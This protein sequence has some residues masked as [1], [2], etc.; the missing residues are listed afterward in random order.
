[1]GR[2]LL[3][4]AAPRLRVRVTALVAVACFWL[5]F[6]ASAGS[7]ASTACKTLAGVTPPTYQ[8][9]TGVDGTQ[10]GTLRWALTCANGT[11]GIQETIAFQAPTGGAELVV[12][13]T[14]I[15]PTITDRV[16]VVGS[17]DASGRPL[18]RI[19]GSSSPGAAYG[20]MSNIAAVGLVGSIQKIMF[21]GWASSGADA[22]KL[23]GAGRVSVTGSVFG[24]D[25]LS[26]GVSGNYTG[27]ELGNNSPIGG[28]TVALRN[29]FAGNVRGIQVNGNGCGAATGGCAIAGNLIGTN[30]SGTAR[31]GNTESGIRVENAFASIS[32][33][34]IAG[35]QGTGIKFVGGGSG[36]TVTGNWIGTSSAG[37]RLENL[38]PGISIEGATGVTVG[39]P[40][41]TDANTI[42]F[43]AR[44][45]TVISGSGNIFRG[46]KIFGNSPL[47]IDLANDGPTANDPG[48][49]DPGA[50]GR[51][52]Y[53][54]LSSAFSSGPTLTATM[55]LDSAPGTYVVDF[56]QGLDNDC[57]PGSRG[58][59]TSSTY[60]GSKTVTA[61]SSSQQ[62][63]ITIACASR[64]RNHRHDGDEPVVGHIGDVELPAVPRSDAERRECQRFDARGHAGDADPQC[65]RPGRAVSTQLRGRLP[66]ERGVGGADQRTVLL[67]GTCTAQVTYTPASNSN[68]NDAFTYTASDGTNTSAPGTVSVAVS[69]VN[70]VPSF[71]KGADQGGSPRCWR[72]RGRSR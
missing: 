23:Q 63:S 50:N 45:I 46:N 39:S 16:D 4:L 9:T 65:H 13:P 1:M 64:S 11:A 2:G 37:T 55:V 40:V 57:G 48:D 25:G 52:N 31:V 14:S 69:A 18:V 60:L 41:A 51:Q 5:L 7:A 28:A 59:G 29:V 62:V 3:W 72:M 33:N 61:S 38:G 49:G 67:T 15:L 44:G 10:A 19:D 58:L 8:V 21:S 30:L 6:S 36:G 70:D 24:S 22:L 66:A 35:N 54:A 26:V 68:G 12:K 17:A 47:D 71:T 53:P 56:Y 20:L 32:G 27:L 34:V 42:A 43:N